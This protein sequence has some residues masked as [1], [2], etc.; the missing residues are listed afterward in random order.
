MSWYIIECQTQ[1]KNK[2]KETKKY[3]LTD[4]NE[5]ENTAGLSLLTQQSVMLTD[6]G[7]VKSTLEYGQR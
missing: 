6:N 1:R 5:E 4:F 7:H 3:N 2:Q